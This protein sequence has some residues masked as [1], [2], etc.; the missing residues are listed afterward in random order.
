MTARLASKTSGRTPCG[1][2]RT[3]DALKRG[4]TDR[5]VEAPPVPSDS[6]GNWRRLAV[7]DGAPRRR[8]SVRWTRP[9]KDDRVVVAAA[10]GVVVA[11]ADD[12]Y[13]PS[14]HQ[15]RPKLG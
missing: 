8:E 1:R 14:R 6:A 9:T 2:A 15:G 10:V 4:A 5:V 12:W 3:G 13:W 11:A 7:A